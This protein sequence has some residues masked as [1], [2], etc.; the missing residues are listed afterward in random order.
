M[1]RSL[2]TREYKALESE[3]NAECKWMDRFISN[4]NERTAKRKCEFISNCIYK[5]K[6]IILKRIDALM[7]EDYT[8][9][10]HVQRI[11]ILINKY[12]RYIRDYNKFVREYQ[13]CEHKI[14]PE[15]KLETSFGKKK[16]KKEK[17][18][19]IKVST[20]KNKKYM[21]ILNTN[22]VIHFGD[23]RYQQ[24][25][26]KLKKYSKKNHLDKSRR[27]NYF[28]RHSGVPTKSKALK[29]EFTKSNGKYNAKILSHEYLW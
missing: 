15:L 24:Y 14:F 22:R 9:R 18:K 11:Q 10:G 13:D 28:L 12:N 19:S 20:R 27:R 7:A 26:D 5:I 17:I 2:L 16:T 4:I 29:K 6:A 1:N 3:F 23:K 21:A 25:F 8:D